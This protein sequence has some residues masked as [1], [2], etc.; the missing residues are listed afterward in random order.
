MSVA[1]D[2]CDPY[3]LTQRKQNLFPCVKTEVLREDNLTC[4]FIHIINHFKA[5][6]LHKYNHFQAH[7]S[8]TNKN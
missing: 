6:Y 4:V 2:I 7:L 1:D 5:S 8:A 3:F